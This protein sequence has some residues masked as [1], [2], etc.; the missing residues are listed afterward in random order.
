MLEIK[1]LKGDLIEVR[2]SRAEQADLARRNLE[3]LNGQ[4]TATYSTAS[5]RPAAKGK[6]TQVKKGLQK[7]R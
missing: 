1:N 2:L 5:V 4:A 7:K 3:H 6:R